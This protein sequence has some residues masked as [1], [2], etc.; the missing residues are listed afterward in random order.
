MGSKFAEYF[1]STLPGVKLAGAQGRK[2]AREKII[3][4][5]GEKKLP[6]AALFS[7]FRALF[8]T[9]CRDQLNSWK[10]LILTSPLGT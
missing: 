10:R 7:I 5:R 1:Y 3:K 4:K 9:L 6:L 2:A 8:S